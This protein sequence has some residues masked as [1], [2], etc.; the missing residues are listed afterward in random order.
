MQGAAGIDKAAQEHAAAVRRS[1][2]KS[3]S[4]QLGG[5][6]W[7]GHLVSLREDFRGVEGVE[8]LAAALGHDKLLAEHEVAAGRILNVWYR[9]GAQPGGVF[10][11]VVEDLPRAFLFEGFPPELA[12]KMEEWKGGRGRTGDRRERHQG[13][14]GRRGLAEGLEGR[15]GGVPGG[16]GRGGSDGPP[17]R[18]HAGGPPPRRAQTATG[19]LVRGCAVASDEPPRKPTSPLEMARLPRFP[20]RR[21]LTPLSVACL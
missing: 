21:G 15:A 14:R 13:I 6:P 8:K 5:R 18:E 17:E 2:G 7:L 9:Q 12:E 10:H 1:I 16:S 4:L 20:S 3:K 19:A 11:A